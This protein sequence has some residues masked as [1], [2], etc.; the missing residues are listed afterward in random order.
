MRISLLLSIA[1]LM[2]SFFSGC[3]HA[4]TKKGSDNK[5]SLFLMKK[6]GSESIVEVN[7]IAGSGIIDPDKEGIELDEKQVQR[8]L[9]VKDGFYYNFRKDFF[10]QYSTVNK[11]MEKVDSIQLDDFYLSNYHWIDADTLL[12]I[13]NAPDY[14]QTKFA[15]INVKDMTTTQGALA[16]PKLF[17]SYTAMTIGVSHLRKDQLIVGYNYCT[18]TDSRFV[19]GDTTYVAVFSYPAM[20]RLTIEKET[21]SVYPGGENTVE[22]GSFQDEKGDFY[23]LACPGIAL[24]DRQDKATGI[25]R[26]KAN[27]NVLD[28][29]YFFNVS[30]SPIQN[31]A[32]SVYYLGH[33]KALVRNERK[34]LYSS[35]DE[36]WKVAH[37]EFYV[38]DL[39]SQT[40]SKLDL[41]LDK[42]TRRQCVVVE[43]GKA[44]ISL[45]SDSAGHYIWIYDLK[46]NGLSKGLQIGGDTDFIMRMD[47]LSKN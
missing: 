28:S 9:I 20:K 39:L 26:M 38:I 27:Q 8:D 43:N 17:G 4:D 24:G 25:F 5:Y 37:Y 6:D 41:P 14:S 13:G 42:G 45:N 31:H 33:G 12:L 35:W 29:A 2:L 10:Y 40:V 34:D 23:F 32:Y 19:N 22:P 16:L 1:Y 47:K 15:K 21:R 18:K 30:A 3:H 36:H 44:Y 7:D 11:Q 46:T